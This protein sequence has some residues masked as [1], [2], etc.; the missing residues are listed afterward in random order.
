[1]NKAISITLAKL[2]VAVAWADGVIQGEE[3]Q[4]LKD[5]VYKIPD[6]SREDWASIE[7]YMDSPI[8]AEECAQLMAKL[9]T[10]IKSDEDKQYAMRAL[11]DVIYADG[12]VDENERK[13][14][15]MIIAEIQQTSV[16]F[17]KKLEG[18][19]KSARMKRTE[20][21]NRTPRRER[22]IEEFLENPIFYRSFHKLTDD[23]V[24]VHMDKAELEKL[25][26]AGALMACIAQADGSIHPNEVILIK[27]LLK[28]Y[29]HISEQA[30]TIVSQIA[31]NQEV[32]GMDILRMCRKFYTE[33]DAKSRLEFFETLVALVKSDYDVHPNERERLR[34][35]ATH[36]KI[37]LDT[38]LAM[39]PPV[40]VLSE[41]QV[42]NSFH[43]EDTTEDTTVTHDEPFVSNYVEAEISAESLKQAPKLKPVADL[44]RKSFQD[45]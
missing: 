42:D 16:G 35:I 34:A 45:I 31:V 40:G 23:G 32:A 1:M 44:K 3:I 22:N 37:P 29:W 9:K 33:N 27:K 39:L 41:D 5:L 17:D 20:A 4:V 25:C 21:L 12:H 14:Y 2:L 28:K 38:L 36:L 18:V 15:D 13:L 11:R 7:V 10:L 19:F 8:S 26:V 24:N 43:D 30:A 6:L